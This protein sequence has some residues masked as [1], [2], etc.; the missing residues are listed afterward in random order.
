M[1]AASENRQNWALLIIYS[2]YR[3][4]LA[5]L[6]TS[7]F[8]LTAADP[9]VGKHAPHM[10]LL[11]TSVYSL[12]AVGLL[13]YQLISKRIGNSAQVFTSLMVDILA[14]TLISYGSGDDVAGMSLLI[15]PAIAAGNMLLPGRLG[16]LLAAMASIA[17][18]A[19]SSYQVLYESVASNEFAGAGMLGLAFFTTS[20]AVQYLSQRIVT[21]QQLAESRKADVQQLLRISERIVQNMR[22]GILVLKTD[23]TIR[24]INEAAAEMLNIRHRNFHRPQM[25]PRALLEAIESERRNPAH[26]RF[27][28]SG[29]LLQIG[30]ATLNDSELDDRLLFIEDVS[31]LAQQAQQLK[32]ASLGQFT[33]SIA[34]E[35]RNPLGAISHA[36]QLLAES[37]QLSETDRRLTDIVKQQSARMNN[38]IENILQLSR[39]KQP[40]PKTF[41]LC[42]WLIRFCDDYEAAASEPCTLAT[43]NEGEAFTVNVDRDQ[44][45]QILTIIVDNGL[46]YSAAATGERKLRLVL[47]NHAN[48]SA[49]MLDVIDYGPGIVEADRDRLFEPFYTTESHGTGLGLYIG[50]ELCDINQIHLS[51]QRNDDGNSCFRLS[52]S[53]PDRR[54]II[55]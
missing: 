53:H 51:W 2:G 1:Q 47:R 7:M 15:L 22:T 3:A 44:L 24:L 13:V 41:D 9:V 40:R 31:Q 5:T 46:R 32:L 8:L 20:I 6:L 34:H 25:A 17:V 37:G 11:T 4:L 38:I 36:A 48:L 50:K 52:F 28:D 12:Y 21:A 29:R 30:Q 55:E 26:V 27:E 35:I 42:E 18:I 23:G 10:F 43:E 14:L 49:P 54:H 33:A 39:R 19:E 45:H 16:V